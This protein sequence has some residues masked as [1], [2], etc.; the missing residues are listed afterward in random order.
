MKFVQ[1]VN[2]IEMIKLDRKTAM[3]VFIFLT[4]HLIA[5]IDQDDIIVR[6]PIA[7][8]GNDMSIEQDSFLS[9]HDV[10]NLS[11]AVNGYEGFPVGNGDLGAMGWT[12]TDRLFFQINK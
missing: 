12:P 9:Q 6:N 4:N 2:L 1:G 8:N 7:F 11:P 3:L 5:Q 10:V